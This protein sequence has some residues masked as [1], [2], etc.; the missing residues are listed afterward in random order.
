MLKNF[1][2]FVRNSLVF[3]LVVFIS[4]MCCVGSVLGYEYL[5]SNG[6]FSFWRA[7]DNPPVKIS[8]ILAA[9]SL[10]IWIETIDGTIYSMNIACPYLPSDCNVMEWIK[11]NPDTAALPVDVPYDGIEI[12]HGST[13]TFW[14]GFDLRFLRKPNRNVVECI[15]IVNLS[16]SGA[17]TTY[18]A[19]TDNDKIQYLTK[20]PAFGEFEFPFFLS[21]MKF[22]GLLLGVLFYILFYNKFLKRKF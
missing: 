11:S 5:Q 14:D 4:V 15:R 1:I 22:V 19:R 9:D 6:F 12:D 20:L 3:I 17:G 18:F 21:V 10:S 8:K 7:V 2:I 13:C 16:P